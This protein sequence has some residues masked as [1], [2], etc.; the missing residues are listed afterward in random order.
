MTSPAFDGLVFFSNGREYSGPELDQLG[1]AE[2][3]RHLIVIGL[4]RSGT[5]ACASVL[6]ELGFV[7]DTN[8]DPIMDSKRLR[9]LR[10]RRKVEEFQEEMARWDRSGER[11]YWKD[12]KLRSPDFANALT[13]APESVGYLFVFRDAL[14]PAIR[15]HRLTNTSF[16]D[17]L[18]RAARGNLGLVESVR[19][20]QA[21]K[22]VLM[23]YEKLLLHS[24]RT[25]R[26]LANFVGITDEKKIGAAVQAISPEPEI[27][28]QIAMQGAAVL[29]NS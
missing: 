12:P 2:P 26:A 8:G 18:E 14:N 22:V 10:T 29:Q 25:V 20:L 15:N 27:Y 5:T 6:S 24:D 11:W 21:R 17:S 13:N 19:R 28:A 4:G 3:P 16:I 9:A 7:C 1:E 23:S